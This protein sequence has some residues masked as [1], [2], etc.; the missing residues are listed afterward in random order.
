M[1][2]LEIIS[3]F[4]EFILNVVAHLADKPAGHWNAR[5]YWKVSQAVGLE[6]K[7]YGERKLFELWSMSYK[8]ELQIELQQRI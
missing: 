1:E 3:L 7:N 4:G 2:T 8:V 5:S 6:L